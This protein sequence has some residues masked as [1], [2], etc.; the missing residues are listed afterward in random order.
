MTYALLNGRSVMKY[1][2]TFLL[3]AAIPASLQILFE[4]SSYTQGFAINT[5]ITLCV[6]LLSKRFAR[7]LGIIL[8]KVRPKVYFSISLLA[9]LHFGMIALKWHFGYQID[10]LKYWVGVGMFIGLGLQAALLSYVVRRMVDKKK[11]VAVGL[12]VTTYLIF[13]IVGLFGYTVF[14]SF[15]ARKPIFFDSEISHYALGL[16]PLYCA[17]TVLAKRWYVRW[18]GHLTVC[19]IG[20]IYQSTTLLLVLLLIVLVTSRTRVALPIILVALGVLAVGGAQLT[21]Y[22]DR[23]SLSFNENAMGNWSYLQGCQDA[24]LN[25]YDSYGLGVGLQQF[26]V[27]EPR[28]EIAQAVF[29]KYGGYG[30][31]FDGSFGAAKIIAEFGV[32]GVVIVGFLTVEVWRAARKLRS[33]NSVPLYWNAEILDVF[34][35]S[36]IYTFFVYLFVRGGGYFALNYVYL[37]SGLILINFPCTT[38]SLKGT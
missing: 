31:R 21:Y 36:F 2:L 23:L 17:W 24:F 26:G 30:N 27:K 9:L 1:F 8:K 25:F 37:V 11:E 33:F 10:F 28:G 5:L 22:T 35:Y 32:L 14:G 12:F 4:L 6:V 34:A 38:S 13:G 20:Y 18:S 7:Y 19:L 29:L 15:E 3:L 16:L